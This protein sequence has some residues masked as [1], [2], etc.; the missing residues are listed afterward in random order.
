CGGGAYSINGA[1]YTSAP[2]SVRNGDM[3][4]IQLTSAASFATHTQATVTIG[5]VSG[6]FDVITRGA[7]PAQPVPL[8]GR[9]A[10]ALLAAL[11]ALVG[12]GAVRRPR[13]Q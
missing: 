6:T 8:L 11:L 7:P 1:A 9:G 10:I 2:G 3:V 13:R 12:L 5:G 4:S